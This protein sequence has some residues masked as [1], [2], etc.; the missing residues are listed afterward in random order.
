MKN[1]EK[2]ERIGFA[3]ENE[4]EAKSPRVKNLIADFPEPYNVSFHFA[5]TICPCCLGHFIVNGQIEKVYISTNTSHAT[6]LTD[7][8]FTSML[9][10]GKLQV[11]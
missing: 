3:V 9:T 6:I 11:F 1:Q 5:K 8:F 4:Q 7:D 2:Q 10:Q